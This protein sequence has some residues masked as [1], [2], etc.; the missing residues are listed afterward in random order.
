MLLVSFYINYKKVFDLFMT[1]NNTKDTKIR[2]IQ[3]K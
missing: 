1:G 2:V 3:K